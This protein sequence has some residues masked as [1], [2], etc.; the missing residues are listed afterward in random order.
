MRK[1]TI[2]AI[3]LLLVL[4]ALPVFAAPVGTLSVGQT[5]TVN[6]IPNGQVDYT[7]T[8]TETGD[9]AVCLEETGANFEG[10]ACLD[11]NVP[12]PERYYWVEG[13]E[14]KV[15]SLTAGKTYTIRITHDTGFGGTL[16]RKLRLEKVTSTT[17][18]SL[19]CPY[20]ENYPGEV[21]WVDPVL[22]HPG[23]V[24]GNFQWSSSNPAVAYIED[25]GS[26]HAAVMPVAPGT[27][28]ITLTVD[29]LTASCEFVV[30]DFPAIPIG[31]S[32]DFQLHT[33]DR[34][35][36]SIT[37]TETGRYAIWHKQQEGGLVVTEAGIGEHFGGGG[38]NGGGAIYT[39]R[40]GV[41]YHAYYNAGHAGEDL[42]IED[43]VYAEK[44]RPVERVTLQGEPGMLPVGYRF[45]LEAVADPIYG[46]KEG[47][48]WS[49]SDPAVLLLEHMDPYDGRC[50][51]VVL[52]E[53]TATVT[54]TVGGVSTS[55]EYG[56]PNVPEWQPDPSVPLWS[57]GTTTTMPLAKE[58]STENAFCAPEDGYYRFTLQADQ[59]TFVTLHQN[60]SSGEDTAWGHVGI[61]AG[62][63]VT[64]DVYLHKDRY[65][66]IQN[67]GSF[68]GGGTLTGKVERLQITEKPVERIEVTASPT[69]E[70]KDDDYGGLVD[71]YYAFNP[72]RAGSIPSLQVSVYYTDGTSAV[73]TQDQL[74]WDVR[75]ELGLPGC[76]WN[77]IPVELCLMYE[78]T[79]PTDSIWLK[80]PQDVVARLRYMGVSAEFVMHL[81][82][83]HDHVMVFHPVIDPT[84]QAPG[85]E[86]HY[87]CSVCDKI[88]GDSLGEFRFHNES[89]LILEY[90]NEFVVDQDQAQEIVQQAKPGE[91]VSLPL[92]EGMTHVVL[93]N[94]ALQEI[95]NKENTLEL[96]LGDAIVQ[97]DSAALSAILSQGGG[98]E[99]A[100]QVQQVA[101]EALKAPQQQALESREV[102]CV[103]SAQVLCGDSSIH[104]FGGGQVTLQIPF[105]PEP[106]KGY[107]VI[108]VADDG[109]VTVIPSTYG[110]G[111]LRFSTGHF[112]E[113]AI[114]EAPDAPP[115]LPA[116]D[117]ES[118][119]IW[120][121]P[122]AVVA[123]VGV[124][125]ALRIWKRRKK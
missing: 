23:A 3:A 88:Y 24:S 74:T 62:G 48:Q 124:L 56:I 92:P 122:V 55:W 71:G 81:T 82:P 121:I 67:S 4:L 16:A 47:V 103:L 90:K 30:V 53:G 70:F 113:Y 78:G 29:G 105:T 120:L 15:F 117:P 58:A 77:G 1:Y 99:V 94:Q 119:L 33:S 125:A 115:A 108:Y 61:A 54:V 43:T 97:V 111:F 34:R 69:Y 95:V 93:P 44:V 13:W 68:E 6:A 20:T 73:L 35:V 96:G 98:A 39:L 10:W 86:A 31:G 66:Q 28:T 41:T 21:V 36:F 51:A 52:K 42:I 17:S 109:T 104:D 79:V 76:T 25:T 12:I 49:V 14:G 107:Q 83:G 80:T 72:F 50:E 45:L 112:S 89:D 101:P 118:S 64:M 38:G 37:P 18:L 63:E 5:V 91:N 40:A 84:P 9:Y 57:L 123:V 106:G 59:E 100:L 11:G 116:E 22:S 102:V 26:I 75:S 27:T 2:L 65:Y 110:D 87:R 114:V 85:M 8:P 19:S 7:F 46:V 32:L 60:Y